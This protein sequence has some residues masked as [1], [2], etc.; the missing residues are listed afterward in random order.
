[1]P[2]VAL[3]VQRASRLGNLR[4]VHPNLVLY[5]PGGGIF[6]YANHRCSGPQEGVSYRACYSVIGG[7][8]IS[9]VH[10]VYCGDAKV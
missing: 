10:S 5:A 4:L 8:W 1:M 7:K 2:W 9:T 3:A 6:V